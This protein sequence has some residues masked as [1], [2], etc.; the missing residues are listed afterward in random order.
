[1]NTDSARPR[2][3]RHH[4]PMTAVV[5]PTARG[6]PWALRF[7]T[8]AAVILIAIGAGTLSSCSG[9][10]QTSDTSSPTARQPDFNRADTE[11]V[12]AAGQHL[13]RTLTAAR[14]AETASGNRH[15][16]AFAHDVIQLKR[17]QVDQVAAWLDQWGRQGADFG[18]DSHVDAAAEPDDGLTDETLSRLATSTGPRFD[19]LFIAA[20][21][22][23]LDAGAAIWTAEAAAGRNPAATKL[24]G[25]LGVEEADL[26]HRAR[27]VL[28]P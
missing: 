8:A 26:A 15:V 3:P 2:S 21:T 9:N 19:R 20:M 14:L 10:S 16:Q 22:A 5:N 28:A 11:F 23:H 27:T 7:P 17:R 6:R 24:A 1:M 25:Q 12:I 4:V 13:G 18:H